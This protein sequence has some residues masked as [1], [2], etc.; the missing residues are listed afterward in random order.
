MKKVL[1]LIDFSENSLNA[2]RYGQY[3]FQPFEVTFYLFSAYTVQ[4]SNL[5]GDEWGNEWEN[6]VHIGVDND[7]EDILTHF[8]KANKK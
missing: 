4:P 5:L 7:L 8:K 1:V 3:L 6:A 2:L